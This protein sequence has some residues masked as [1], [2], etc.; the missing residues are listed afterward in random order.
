M[1]ATLIV[2]AIA[3]VVGVVV[4]LTYSLLEGVVAGF[5][6]LGGLVT[7]WILVDTVK[8]KI[9]GFYEK[10]YAPKKSTNSER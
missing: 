7:S 3:T 4:A 2:Y 5:A 8:E 1:T 6:A 10:K 9:E